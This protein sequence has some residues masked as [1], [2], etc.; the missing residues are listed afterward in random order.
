MVGSAPGQ[1]DGIG[2]RRLGQRIF[3]ILSLVVSLTDAPLTSI[4]SLRLTRPPILYI[5]NVSMLRL[6]RVDFVIHAFEV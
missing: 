6:R 3:G 2:V 5:V 1:P 4:L